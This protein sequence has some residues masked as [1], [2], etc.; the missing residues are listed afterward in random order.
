LWFYAVEAANGCGQ[1]SLGT[2]SHGV[3]R[4]SP[5]ACVDPT[6]DGDLDGYPDLQDNCPGIANPTQ[7]DADGDGLGDACD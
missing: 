1:G 3:E 2:D 4:T 5:A 7:S 6:R